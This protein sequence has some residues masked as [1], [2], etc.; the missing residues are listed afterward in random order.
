MRKQKHRRKILAMI[1]AV[2]LGI[3][4]FP[5]N[6]YDYAEETEA[7]WETET[8][9]EMEPA[10][11]MNPLTPDGNLTLVDDEGTS[12]GE[13][14]QFITV[15]TKSGNYFYLVIDRDD[16]GEQTVHFLNQVDEADLMALMDEEEA[17]KYLPIVEEPEPEPILPVEEPEEEDAELS[18]SGL[19]SLLLVGAAMA[20]A[21]AV[22]L[23]LAKDKKQAQQEKPDPDADYPEE[24]EEYG[25]ED[26]YEIEEET[27]DEI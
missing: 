6:V 15:V 10:E 3:G 22:Y 12:V 9:K 5:M 17:A 25:D 23:N 4:L 21:T 16:K 24:D 27:E 13:G 8:M 18:L 14:K 2:I 11:P 20:A 19:L 1:M 7:E 26:E